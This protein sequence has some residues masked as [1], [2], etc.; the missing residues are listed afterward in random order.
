M[1]VRMWRGVA[2]REMSEAY[3]V[4]FRDTGLLDY[5]ATPGNRS[6]QVLQRPRDNGIEW[7]IVTSWDSWDAIRAF[8]GENPE[9]AVYYPDDARYFVEMPEGVEHYEVILDER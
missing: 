1:V 2:R 5:R 4:Y 3:L 7:L 6:V 8:A 9:R